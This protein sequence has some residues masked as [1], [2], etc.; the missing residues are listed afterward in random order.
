MMPYYEVDIGEL[1][2]VCGGL[3][4]LPR[5]SEKRVMKYQVELVFSKRFCDLLNE[6]NFIM[7]KLLVTQ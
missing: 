6:K 1:G 3:L 7:K 4:F 2:Y 5:V